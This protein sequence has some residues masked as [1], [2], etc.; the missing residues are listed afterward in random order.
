LTNGGRL[1]VRPSLIF[2]FRVRRFAICWNERRRLRAV[3][4]MDE[5]SGFVMS[6]SAM[7]V[8]IAETIDGAAAV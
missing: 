8:A 5:M 3:R 4:V 7:S 1:K 6:P 2:A